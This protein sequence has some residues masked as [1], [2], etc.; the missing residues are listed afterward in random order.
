M[1]KNKTKDK[2]M[3]DNLWILENAVGILPRKNTNNI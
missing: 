3:K 2:E 1:N